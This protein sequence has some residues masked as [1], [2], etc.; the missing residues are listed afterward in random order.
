MKEGLKFVWL[1]HSLN[2]YKKVYLL[3]LAFLTWVM[4]VTLSSSAFAQAGGSPQPP[5]VDIELAAASTPQVGQELT[6]T[7]KVIPKENMY[8]DISC[9]F[10]QG[11]K[12]VKEEGD[13]LRPYHEKNVNIQ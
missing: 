13:S 3:G 2:R 12:L 6:L 1:G 8:A 4:L 7:L 5:P 11:V 9:L 10:P